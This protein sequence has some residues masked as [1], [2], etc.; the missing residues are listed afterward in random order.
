MPDLVMLSSMVPDFY[1]G[2]QSCG[3][4]TV[5]DWLL[6]FSSGTCKTEADFTSKQGVFHSSCKPAREGISSVK[7]RSLNKSIWIITVKLKKQI[8]NVCGLKRC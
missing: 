6:D 1:T 4:G 2:F 5:T 7:T 3:T 8:G